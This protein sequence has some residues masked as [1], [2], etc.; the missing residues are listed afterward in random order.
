MLD[1]NQVPPVKSSFAHIKSLQRE[2][3]EMFIDQECASTIATS[4]LIF[5]NLNSSRKHDNEIGLGVVMLNAPMVAKEEKS[6]S[7]PFLWKRNVLAS[8]AEAEGEV[9]L[10]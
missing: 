3:Y 8:H 7:S 6:G 4:E 10:M 5:N 9:F 2:L 1:D